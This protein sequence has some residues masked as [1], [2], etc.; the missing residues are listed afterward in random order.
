MKAL[1][2][3]L[4]A[5]ASVAGLTAIM[6]SPAAAVPFTWNPSLTSGT[7]LSSAGAFTSD[8]FFTSDYSHIV[9]GA[10]SGS[11]NDPV[12]NSIIEHS[13]LAINSFA[14][15]NTPGLVSTNNGSPTAG[16][17]GYRLYF[18]VTTTSH[19][20]D[21]VAGSNKFFLGSFDTLSYTM[22][23]DV[24]GNCDFGASS[25][26][27]SITGCGADTQLQLATGSLAGPFNSVSLG[28][29]P[30][31]TVSTDIDLGTNAGGFFV[32]PADLATFLFSSAFTNDPSS[33]VTHFANGGN[34][35][36]ITGGGGNTSLIGVPEPLTLSLFGVGLAGAVGLRRRRSKKA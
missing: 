13:I 32:N 4:I 20:T 5:A 27:I 21:V 3:A 26:G 2:K 8:N 11:A 1:K 35:I 34:T 22:Y 17:T 23:G 31:A 15:V 29:S 9:L 25:A 6:A 16:A 33:N 12:Y 30:A 28:L 36:Y 19:L 18:V 10:N 7:A 14:N 24:G